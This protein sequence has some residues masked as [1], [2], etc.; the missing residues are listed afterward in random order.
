[1][2]LHQ[3][4][5]AALVVEPSPKPH[6]EPPKLYGRPPFTGPR[7]TMQ[8]GRFGALRLAL[9]ATVAFSHMGVPLGGF[10]PG[11]ASVVAFYAIS[12]FV[13]SALLAE[14]FPGLSGVPRFLIDRFMRLA[15]QYYFY[16]ALGAF[17]IFA[18]GWQLFQPGPADVVNISANL[19]II[20][21]VA[22]PY[23]K[24]IQNLILNIPAWTLGLELVFYCALPFIILNTMTLYTTAMAGA[25]MVALAMHNIIHPDFWAYRIPPGPF[26]FFIIGVAAWRSDRLLI[27]GIA[28][29]LILLALSLL[30]TGRI[31]FAWNASL[32]TGS[33]VSL[34]VVPWLGRA[35]R[36]RI[37]D[38]LG[39][40][41]YGCY[42]S[43]WLFV[44]ALLNYAGM[45]WAVTVAVVGSVASG[46]LSFYLIERP[47]IALR[48][49][50]RKALL[51]SQARRMERQ[52]TQA[53]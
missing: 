46:F 30:A 44:V 51:H 24:S 35:P 8:T 9:A 16:A 3:W 20:G 50:M 40:G 22:H 49:T 1:M 13:M 21:L 34:L 41:S 53:S 28:A 6:N 25:V 38:L 36:S 15:P 18:L 52:I 45:P 42:L 39:A 48:K 4:C 23:V 14:S 7:S 27:G 10:H 2:S 43:H 37:D 31:N 5:R 47:T 12:G 33:I 19:S 29:Y 26:L 32:L 17:F 11:I